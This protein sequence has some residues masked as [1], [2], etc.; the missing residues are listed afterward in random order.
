MAY[1]CHWQNWMRKNAEGLSVC[2]LETLVFSWRS[3]ACCSVLCES[4]G[5][6]VCNRKLKSLCQKIEGCVHFLT[7]IWTVYIWSQKMLF[8]VNVK[9]GAPKKQKQICPSSF[10]FYTIKLTSC[11]RMDLPHS[12]VWNFWALLVKLLVLKLTWLII[13]VC[14]TF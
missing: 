6:W 10:S 13:T 2:T 14:N 1:T 4:G 7:C 11:P 5:W 9:T 3:G 12:I 8:K